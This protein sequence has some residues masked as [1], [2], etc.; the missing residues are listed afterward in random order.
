MT[1]LVVVLAVVVVVILVV[2]IVAA[3]NMRAEDPDE[4]DQPA[5]RTKTRGGQGRGHQA[6][7]GQDNRD[8]RYDRS[9]R[10]PNSRQGNSS[11]PA[12]PAGRG[13]DQRI[14]NS[15]RTGADRDFG[16]RQARGFEDNGRP[17]FGAGDRRRSDNGMPAGPGQRRETADRC[18]ARQART[19][20]TMEWLAGGQRR[21]TDSR[22]SDNGLPV[23]PPGDR[24]G[25]DSRENGRAADDRA[26]SA[27]ER[28]AAGAGAGARTPAPGQALSGQLGVG[29]QRVGQALRRG[30]LDDARLGE[31][32]VHGDAPA[33]AGAARAEGRRACPAPGAVR[34][35]AARGR[36]VR[37]RPGRGPPTPT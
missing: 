26:E 1:K 22:G 29:Q 9:E 12:R 10:R 17:A 23:M 32:D 15:R 25:A 21:G 11:R 24:R 4:F 20:V 18:Q 37:A 2:V 27:Q 35:P 34:G 3:R 36:P 30:L 6:R 33:Q 5:T 14:Q 8:Q 19:A 28:Q 13:P 7:G 16:P 31:A